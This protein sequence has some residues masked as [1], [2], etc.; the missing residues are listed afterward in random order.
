MNFKELSN[1]SNISDAELQ[2]KDIIS[3]KDAGA[4]LDELKE[5][6]P[7]IAKQLESDFPEIIKA[8]YK[9]VSNSQEDLKL[10]RREFKSEFTKLLKSEAV[11]AAKDKGIKEKPSIFVELMPAS[12]GVAAKVEAIHAFKHT[13]LGYRPESVLV[14]SLEEVLDICKKAGYTV[15]Q[16]NYGWHVEGEDAPKQWIVVK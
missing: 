12:Y 9:R 15:K 11:K 4:L 6:F 13:E 3:A 1:L 8:A 2:T 10:Q 7:E 5:R 16:V 14:L